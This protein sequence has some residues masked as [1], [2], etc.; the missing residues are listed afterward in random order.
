MQEYH[1]V[2][3]NSTNSNDFAH[4]TEYTPYQ[5]SSSHSNSVPRQ[6]IIYDQRDRPNYGPA[7]NLHQQR[8]LSNEPRPNLISPAA[9]SSNP[10]LQPPID[11]ASSSH[12]ARTPNTPGQ[13]VLIRTSQIPAS[14]LAAGSKTEEVTLKFNDDLEKMALGWS[15]DEW[16]CRRRLVQFTRQQ[17]RSTVHATFQPISQSEYRPDSIVISCI[18]REDMNECYLT[19]VDT[20]Y[21]LEGLV[22]TKFT[23]AEKNRIRRN[24]EVFKPITCSKT[25]SDAGKLYR[26]I[27]GYSNPRPRNIDKDLKIFAWKA[28]APALVKIMGKYVSLS[29][30][31]THSI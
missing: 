5:S 26:L 13:Y 14:T 8:H 15:P 18:F 9:S 12:S 27:V 24:L 20:I 30:L 1:S 4:N 19:S 10:R 3:D 28:L 21:L 25:N 11:S 7:P 16:A 29:R 31:L 23:V 6:P 2:P 22:G 17:N